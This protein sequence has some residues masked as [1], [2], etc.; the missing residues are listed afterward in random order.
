VEDEWGHS[1]FDTES[2]HDPG[3]KVKSIASGIQIQADLICE[4]EGHAFS[5]KASDDRIVVEVSNLITG[6]RLIRTLSRQP[7]LRINF[8]QL[9]DCLQLLGSTLEL[10]VSGTCVATSGGRDRSYLGRLLRFKGIRLLPI[11]ALLTA[12]KG[13]V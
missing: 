7:S 1:N 4:F 10:R 13:R 8:D 11:A 5:I 9:S 3:K 12:L 6:I 2:R